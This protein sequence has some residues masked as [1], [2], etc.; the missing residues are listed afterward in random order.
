MNKSISAPLRRYWVH[1]VA[2][3]LFITYEIW[4]IW[5]LNGA[6]S[7]P[8]NY[9]LHYLVIILWFYLAGNLVLPWTFQANLAWLWKSPL[10]AFALYVIFILSNYALDYLLVH[11]RLV[12]I[13]KHFPLDRTYMGKILFR[14]VYILGIAL[15]YFYIKN[16][17]G[18][19]NLSAEM[20]KRQLEMVIEGERTKR[21]LSKA[22]N[23][24]LKAQINPH[25]LFN[26]LD[27]VYHSINQ[28]CQEAADAVMTL[29]QM[30]RY[31]VESSEQDEYIPLGM[32]M[33]QV[34]KLIHLYQ[35]RRNREL[36]I[37]LD[38]DPRAAELRFI[39]LVLITLVENIFKHG[40]LNDALTG[41]QIG[42]FLQESMLVIETV[43]AV[44]KTTGGQST[45]AGLNNIT[46]RLNFA[47]G[48]AANCEFKGDGQRF[49]TRIAVPVSALSA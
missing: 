18:Q 23:D 1:L 19:K 26:T 21:A 38:F 2:W 41:I 37:I 20:E 9:G 35:L 43:N 14:F 36:N 32:E 17:I 29:S 47:Y 10:S 49:I 22:H 39:P 40:D 8:W 11:F 12:P 5:A 33:D 42:V 7:T 44:A 25:F 30:M 34:E 48:E 3:I 6:L 27:Y 15:A 31:A 4:V 46:E 24:F 16:Y 28:S 13:S 45:R